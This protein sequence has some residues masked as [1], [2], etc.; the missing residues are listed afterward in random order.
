MSTD[1]VV[2]VN[3]VFS[4]LSSFLY[5][6]Y[7]GQQGLLENLGMGAKKW[8]GVLAFMDGHSCLAG[9]AF[10]IFILFPFF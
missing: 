8:G 1:T 4:L 2:G 10:D 9:F 6:L 5:L 3:L 7:E